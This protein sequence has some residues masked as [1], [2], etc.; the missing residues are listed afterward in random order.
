MD[1]KK[2]LLSGAKSLST[3]AY[4]AAT[5]VDQVAPQAVIDA[6][7]AKCMS[8]PELKRPLKQCGQCWCFVQTKT[9]YVQEECPIGKWAKHKDSNE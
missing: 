8:C 2:K 3:I 6:R 7:M 1:L 9:Q 4:N 5:G